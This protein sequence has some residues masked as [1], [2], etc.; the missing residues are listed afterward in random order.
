MY[1]SEA[2]IADLNQDFQPEIIFTTYGDPDNIVHGKSH[3]YLV[4]LDKNGNM[5]HDIKLPVQGT[6]KNGKGAPA[7]PTVM[8]LNGD[9]NLEIIIQT[10]GAG[11]FV[12]TIPGSLE[13]ML[14]WP[15]GRG[16]YLRDGRSWLEANRSIISHDVNWD[17]LVTLDDAITTLQVTAGMDP[18]EKINADASQNGQIS[19]E[20]AI[21]IMNLL[22][23]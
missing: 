13:N 14:I 5:L 2:M 4:I 18:P 23:R 19:V 22:A 15:T 7:A 1:A 21:I 20:E 6:N 8:D 12:Y 17:G 9:Q 11:L 10:F 3:G 16:N